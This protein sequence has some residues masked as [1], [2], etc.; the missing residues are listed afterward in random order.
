[1][2]DLERRLRVLQQGEQL[3][4]PE[5]S[6]EDRLSRLRSPS[7][8]YQE[9]MDDLERRFA[10]LQQGEQSRSPIPDWSMLPSNVQNLIGMKMVDDKQPHELSL[11]DCNELYRYKMFL[12]QQDQTEEKKLL[13]FNHHE[14]CREFKR[15]MALLYK[16]ANIEIDHEL[17]YNSA[18]LDLPKYEIFRMNHNLDPT[19]LNILIDLV[20]EFFFSKLTKQ[21]LG[22]SYDQDGYHK[23]VPILKKTLPNN[24][25]NLRLIESNWIMILY[26]LFKG[27]YVLDDGYIVDTVGDLN[28]EL[29]W[30]SSDYGFINERGEVFGSKI[31]NFITRLGYVIKYHSMIGTYG[32]EYKGEGFSIKQVEERKRKVLSNMINFFEV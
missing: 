22:D 13:M 5:G 27:Q 32:E 12:N 29:E 15:T 25:T 11:D 16:A 14:Y 18:K 1:M 21:L 30:Y 23:D 4:M 2:D 26:I 19:T 31:M 3:E 9:S 10:M 17:F 8:D 6:L 24:E 20:N 7:N 28:E